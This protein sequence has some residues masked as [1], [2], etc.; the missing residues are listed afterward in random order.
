LVGGLWLLNWPIIY[1]VLIVF[2]PPPRFGGVA[3]CKGGNKK[4]PLWWGTRPS[5]QAFDKMAGQ[6]GR[7]CKYGIDTKMAEC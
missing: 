4:T 6:N 3:P 5:W 2:I 1:E 7:N